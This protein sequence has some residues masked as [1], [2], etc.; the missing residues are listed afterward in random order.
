MLD[1][2]L[3]PWFQTF[4]AYSVLQPR[5]LLCFGLLR[6]MVDRDRIERELSKEN[7]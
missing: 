6:M 3:K 5:I 2:A 1:H 4:Y 7:I